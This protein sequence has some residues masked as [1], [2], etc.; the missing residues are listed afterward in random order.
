MRPVEKRRGPKQHK[1]AMQDP[2]NFCKDSQTNILNY[3][4]SCEENCEENDDDLTDFEKEN[5][6]NNAGKQE[7]AF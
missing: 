3:T 4:T 2:E 6:Q 1:P 5:M 7:M